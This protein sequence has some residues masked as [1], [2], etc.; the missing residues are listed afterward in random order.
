MARQRSLRPESKNCEILLFPTA[1]RRFDR[2]VKCPTGRA[3][4]WVKLP[5]VRSLTRVKCSGIAWGGKGGWEWA[6]LEFT[7]TLFLEQRLV[8]EP[9]RLPVVVFSLRVVSLFGLKR[10]F[11]ALRKIIQ[12]VDEGDVTEVFEDHREESQQS[13]CYTIDPVGLFVHL[14]R[15]IRM[16]ATFLAKIPE[17]TPYSKAMRVVE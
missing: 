16:A 14:Y 17:E 12:F 7:G 10:L 3:S 8:I 5:T 6:V 15:L 1:D 13:V 9:T 4:V 11:I 2:K